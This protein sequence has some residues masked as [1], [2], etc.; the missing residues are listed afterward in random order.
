MRYR[1]SLGKLVLGGLQ[2]LLDI[3]IFFMKGKQ[4]CLDILRYILP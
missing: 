3:Q 4:S 1:L 2:L